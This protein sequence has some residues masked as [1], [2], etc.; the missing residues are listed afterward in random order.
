MSKL[1]AKE[2]TELNILTEKVA[3]LEVEV[4]QKDAELRKKPKHT[5]LG[6]YRSRFR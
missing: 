6:F 1:F 5:S 2:P 3:K 4:E